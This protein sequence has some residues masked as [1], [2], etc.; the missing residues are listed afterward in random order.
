MVVTLKEAGQW[1]GR[2]FGVIVL[3]MAVILVIENSIGTGCDIDTD[4][5]P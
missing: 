5:E 1:R 3:M 2:L 4:R